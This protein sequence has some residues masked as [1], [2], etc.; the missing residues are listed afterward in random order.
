MQCLLYIMAGMLHTRDGMPCILYIKT[1]MPSTPT[2]II[3]GIPD[4]ICHQTRMGFIVMKSKVDIRWV[5][6]TESTIH[7]FIHSLRQTA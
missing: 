5:I 2:D 7:S 4:R 1:G 3:S 6:V